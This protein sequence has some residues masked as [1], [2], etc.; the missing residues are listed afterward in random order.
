M[1]DDRS[2]STASF[3]PRSFDFGDVA[4][5]VVVLGVRGRADLQDATRL[6][7]VGGVRAAQ[8]MAARVAPVGADRA[9][10]VVTSARPADG[11]SKRSTAPSPA[12]SAAPAGARR[13]NRSTR[14]R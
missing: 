4:P 9:R 6:N 2:F 12:R 8:D 14:C 5:A 3:D 7:A 1:F 13:S 10:Q 11:E